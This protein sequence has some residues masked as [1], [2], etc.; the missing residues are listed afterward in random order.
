LPPDVCRH[1]NPNRWP[2]P[3]ARNR[4][5]AVP[6]KLTWILS[7]HGHGQEWARVLHAETSNAKRFWEALAAGILTVPVS[8]LRDVSPHGIVC[9]VRI[10]LTCNHR[11][12]SALTIW[13]YSTVGDP[14]RL[15]TAYPTP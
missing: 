4:G 5:Y 6:K 12:T 14:P 10:V 2:D 9:Q 13:H 3:S 11:T 15:V 7:E 8:A 1:A